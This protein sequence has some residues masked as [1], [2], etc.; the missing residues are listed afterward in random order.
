MDKFE[1]FV[2][3]FREVKKLGYTR[4]KRSNSTGI[5]KTFEDLIGVI[6]NNIKEPDLHGF[7]IKSQRA[8][9]ESYVTLVTKSPTIPKS[10]NTRLR[11]NYGSKDAEFEDVLVL[12]TS[13][14]YDKWNTHISGYKWKLDVAEDETKIYVLVANS[15]GEIIDRETYYTYAALEKALSKLKNLAYVLADRRVNDADGVEE[16]FFKKAT[17]CFGFKGLDHFI[18]LLKEGKIM[19]DI[20]VGAYKTGDKYGKTHDHGSGF[21]IKKENLHLLYERFETVE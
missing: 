18:K 8:L 6:E 17:V 11:L 4:S 14:F 13:I 2:K 5:G 15:K 16:F 10:A 21:R 1:L 9:S 19:F 3:D 7:E 20:R 12:H